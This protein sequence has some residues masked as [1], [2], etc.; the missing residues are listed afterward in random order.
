MHPVEMKRGAKM[1]SRIFD[2]RPTLRSRKLATATLRGALALA[3]PFAA[4]LM[5]ARPAHA[6]TKKV[7]YSFTGTPD[8]SHP[9]SSL[10]PNNG[11]LYGTTYDGGL[12]FGTVFQFS[13]NGTGGWTETS[14]YS[15]CPVAG[16]ADG[17]NPTYG[18]RSRRS[19][20]P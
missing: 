20:Y 9:M 16:C 19:C 8:G 1:H 2:V 10:T 4:L 7:I 18:S 12:G 13:P 15:F 11:N 5:A 14:I 17:Q 3:L 6:Q